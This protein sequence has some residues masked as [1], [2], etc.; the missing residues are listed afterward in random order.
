MIE[1]VGHSPN[2]EAPE[3]TAELV[4]D[5]AGEVAPKSLKRRK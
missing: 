4:L 3:E 1:G 2:V 5:F